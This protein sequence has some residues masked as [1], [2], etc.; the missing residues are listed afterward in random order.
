MLRA[1]AEDEDIVDTVGYFA[2]GQGDRDSRLTAVT[3]NDDGLLRSCLWKC[4]RFITD[5]T[6]VRLI[7][8]TYAKADKKYL[9]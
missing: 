6:T 7:I 1:H 5:P 4:S 8:F 2:Y 9:E 3:L